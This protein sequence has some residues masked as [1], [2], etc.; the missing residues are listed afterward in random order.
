M[1]V[2]KTSVSH[3][4]VENA[5]LKDTDGKGKFKRMFS[6]LSVDKGKLFFTKLFLEEFAVQEISITVDRVLK[7]NQASRFFKNFHLHCILYSDENYLFNGNSCI[8]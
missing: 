8:C 6:F 7:S 2:Y 3:F 1:V 4:K 5:S